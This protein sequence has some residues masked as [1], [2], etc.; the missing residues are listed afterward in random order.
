MAAPIK[1]TDPEVA[2]RLRSLAG[3]LETNPIWQEALDVVEE[4]YVRLWRDSKPVA[5]M[6][7]EHA[8]HMV[9]AVGLLRQ[10]VQSFAQTGKLAK[11]IA[12]GNVQRK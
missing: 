1:P 12:A 5:A 3:Q 6:E 8:Y 7:R 4:E 10:Q 11:N 9:Q 2:E